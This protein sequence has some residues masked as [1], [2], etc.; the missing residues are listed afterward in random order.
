MRYMLTIIS[1]CF[2]SI[3][4]MLIIFTP[5]KCEHEEMGKIFS[6]QYQKSTASSS[7]KPF[8]KNCNNYFGY[9][10]F[11]NT[12]ADTSYLDVVKEFTDSDEVIG[13][14]YY[15][16]TATLTVSDHD[17]DKTRIRCEIESGD[18]IVNFSVQFRDEFEESVDLL[19]VGDEVTFSGKLYDEGF[20]WTD[21][22]LLK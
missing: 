13:G 19:Q 15:T 22:E 21:C 12:P 5:A 10:N 9:T 16:M 4:A 17:V 7:V 11:R 1:A 20:G 8:C 3:V 14:E 18:I 2:L 6:F